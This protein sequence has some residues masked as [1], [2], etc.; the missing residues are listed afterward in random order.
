MNTYG[1]RN[2]LNLEVERVNSNNNNPSIGSE[3][4]SQVLVSKKKSLNNVRF[5]GFNDEDNKDKDKSIK[6]TR[7]K[8]LKHISSKILE[9]GDKPKNNYVLNY[10]INNEDYIKNIFSLILI[11]IIC[12]YY[13]NEKHNDIEFKEYFE[14][15]D[16]F[17]SFESLY[18]LNND[19]I[20]KKEINENN[21]EI[22]KK[23][24]NEIMEQILYNILIYIQEINID[25]TPVK[26]CLLQIKYMLNESIFKLIYDKT[27][28]KK[29]LSVLNTTRKKINRIVSGIFN[30]SKEYKIKII[31]YE[32]KK[33][34]NIINKLKDKNEIQILENEIKELQNEII[35]LN[36]E[37]K[38]KELQNEDKKLK[39][40]DEIKKLED[41]NKILKKLN[42]TTIQYIIRDKDNENK[43]CIKQRIIK[44]NK[45]IRKK[46]TLYYNS[47]DCLKKIGLLRIIQNLISLIEKD[48]IIKFLK[49]PTKTGG[50]SR[51]NR[52]MKTITKSRK[53]R[54]SKTKKLF[55]I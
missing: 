34:E 35:I 51:K 37:D 8:F 41:D 23:D 13:N 14:S 19:E 20:K 3:N 46:I 28:K 30:Y 26:D 10:N 32:I 16:S 12:K 40:E 33:F 17:A 53:N 52:K 55:Y 42:N 5:N 18:C 50:K 36:N 1:S 2:S 15:V 47:N 31:E 43:M 25:E 29:A 11:K 38:I 49:D 7:D 54:K 24:I 27:D 45:K 39:N 21:D 22:K 44:D 6:M 9:Q 48:D 4:N